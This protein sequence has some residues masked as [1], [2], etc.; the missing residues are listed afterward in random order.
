MA[1]IA[2]PPREL[3]NLLNVRDELKKEMREEGFELNLESLREWD[4][5]MR[6]IYLS[7]AEYLANPPLPTLQNTDGDPISFVKL[8]F[9][10]RCSPQEAFDVLQSL[11]LDQSPE[12]ILDG[13]TRDKNGNLLEVSFDWLK[14]GNKK[15]KS[16]ENTIMGALTINGASLTAEVNS[17]KRA[18]KIQSEIAKKLGKRATFLRAVHESVDAKLEEMAALSGTP[19]F[20]ESQQEQKEFASRPEVQA[21]LKAQL[22][23]HW[24]GWYNE[25]LPALQNKTPIEAARTKAGRERLEALLIDFERRNEN[26][27]HPALRVDVAAIRKKLGL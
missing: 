23:A 11:A 14:K 8:Y 21:I 19:E 6:D 4:L 24:E 3:A 20:E 10:L 22:E 27:P 16:W 25:R 1:P 7:A 13:A 17:E 9:E 15:H 18:K 5:E 26:V 2:I 12:D